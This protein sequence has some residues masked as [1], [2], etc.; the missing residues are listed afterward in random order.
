MFLGSL[1]YNYPVWRDLLDAGLFIDA[2]QV[3]NNIFGKFS[4]DE[5]H[6]GYGGA[7]KIWGKDNILAQVMVGRSKDMTKYYFSCNK[8]L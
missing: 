2:G 8:R 4:P 3:S 1:E 5:F 7:L 6:Y